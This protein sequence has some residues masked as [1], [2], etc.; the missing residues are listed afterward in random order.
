MLGVYFK[1]VN[2]PC[3]S[4]KSVSLSAVSHYGICSLTFCPQ[5]SPGV[6][7]W[8]LLAMYS[9]TSTW[10]PFPGRA[11]RLPPRDRSMNESVR[12]KCPHPLRFFAK[13]TLVSTM[14]LLPLPIVEVMCN[15][16]LTCSY[17]FGFSQY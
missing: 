1:T 3:S 11:S 6:M 16:E 2:D 12:R 8:S 5:S 7:T 15:F 17:S 14:T 13:D 4:I 9:C 10:A